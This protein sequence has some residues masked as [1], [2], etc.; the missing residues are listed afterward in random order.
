MRSALH[1]GTAGSDWHPLQALILLES[2]AFPAAD[3]GSIFAQV[4]GIVITAAVLL[5]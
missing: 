3:D 5:S 2:P 4:C 1:A